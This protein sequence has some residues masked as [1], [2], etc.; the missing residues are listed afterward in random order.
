MSFLL[1]HTITSQLL[2]TTVAMYSGSW[3]CHDMIKVQW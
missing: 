3:E 1:V 2:S